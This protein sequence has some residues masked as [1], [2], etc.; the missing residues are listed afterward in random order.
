MYFKVTI[1]SGH[2]GAGKSYEKV[3]YVKADNVADVFTRMKDYPDLKSKETCKGISM[4]KPVEKQEY[5]TGKILE[6]KREYIRRLHI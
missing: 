5:E 2:M 6:W 1:E 3:C 4:V